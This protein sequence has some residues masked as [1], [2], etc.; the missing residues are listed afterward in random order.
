LRK[1]YAK[2]TERADRVD[3][4]DAADEVVALLSSD[5]QRSRVTVK[6]AFSEELPLIAADRVQLQQVILNMLTNAIDA[7]AAVQSRDRAITIRTARDEGDG[8]LLSVHDVGAGLGDQ[9]AEALFQPFFT[10]KPSGMGIGL[11][12]SRSI[13][14]SH[15]GRLW[16]APNVGGGATFSFSIPACPDAAPI[17]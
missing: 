10:T 14:E 1:L 11:S 5:L 12:V 16:A 4:N 15:G 9:D 2:K 8:V 17:Q 7:M 3:L 13:I 6:M